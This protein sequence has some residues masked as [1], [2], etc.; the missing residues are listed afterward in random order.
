M[1]ARSDRHFLS[2]DD[3][4]AVIPRQVEQKQVS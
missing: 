3:D 2:Q 1:A 4:E